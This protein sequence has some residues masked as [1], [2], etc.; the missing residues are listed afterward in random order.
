MH[1][2]L[3]TANSQSEMED[4]M[5]TIITVWNAIVLDTWHNTDK[6]EKKVLDALSQAPKEGQLQVKRLIKRKKTKFSDDIRAVIIVSIASSIS[7]WL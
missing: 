4:A 3:I 5:L 1:S 7:A 2:L 6:N